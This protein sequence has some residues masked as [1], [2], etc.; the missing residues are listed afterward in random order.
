MIIYVPAVVLLVPPVG[1]VL[2]IG[3]VSYLEREEVVVGLSFFY[4]GILWLVGGANHTKAAQKQKA[5]TSCQYILSTHLS[6]PH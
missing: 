1:L 2:A 3:A 4:F 6:T 5:H